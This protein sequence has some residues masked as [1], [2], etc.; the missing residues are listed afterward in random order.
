MLVE[1]FAFALVGLVVGATAL[2]SLP[3]YFPSG[4]GLTMGTALVSA[5]LAGV[6]AHFTLDGEY[7]AAC[8]AVSAVTSALITSVLARPDLAAGRQPARRHRPHRAGSHRRHRPA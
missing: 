8:I 3:A 2:L 6:I 7:P 1:T 4:W 5:L